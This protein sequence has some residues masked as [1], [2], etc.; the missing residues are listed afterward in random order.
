MVHFN[1]D[2]Q[3]FNSFADITLSLATALSQL[4]I[5]VSLEPCKLSEDALKVLSDKAVKSLNFLDGSTAF[6]SYFQIKV[7]SLLADSSEYPTTRGVKL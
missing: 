6:K 2:F 4:Q 3:H 1:V 7:V 5:P